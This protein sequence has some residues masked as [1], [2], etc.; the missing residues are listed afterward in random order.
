MSHCEN[1][2]TP[3][4]LPSPDGRV[5]VAVYPGHPAYLCVTLGDVSEGEIDAV[6]LDLAAQ[7]P[8][9]CYVVMVP[10][11]MQTHCSLQRKEPRR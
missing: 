3:Y 1:S 5:H 11:M 8:M 4:L 10:A 2:A 9:P 6:L 7:I